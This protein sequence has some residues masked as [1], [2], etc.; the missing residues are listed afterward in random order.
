M[1]NIFH[2]ETKIKH[3]TYCPGLTNTISPLAGADFTSNFSR[4]LDLKVGRRQSADSRPAELSTTSFGASGPASVTSITAANHQVQ[5]K[6]GTCSPVAGPEVLIL[7]KCMFE[8][9]G[10]KSGHVFSGFQPSSEVHEASW[11]IFFLFP[12][13]KF[14]RSWGSRIYCHSPEGFNM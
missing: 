14:P 2:S 4:A 12:Q 8:T 3:L 9:F 5:T 13:P 6:F 1:L 7:Q 10:R 11:T